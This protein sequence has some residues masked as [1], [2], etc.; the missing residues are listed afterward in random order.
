MGKL[1][2]G[3]LALGIVASMAMFTFVMGGLW[4][5]YGCGQDGL[6]ADVLSGVGGEPSEHRG[7]LKAQQSC[8]RGRSPGRGS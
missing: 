1:P 3:R 8:L 7:W 4:R 5:L 6:A 2:A